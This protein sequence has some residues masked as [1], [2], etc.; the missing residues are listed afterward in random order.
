MTAEARAYQALAAARSGIVTADG[1][2]SLGMRES[3]LRLAEIKIVA[4]AIEAAIAEERDACA[5]IA[6]EASETLSGGNWGGPKSCEYG[7]AEVIADAIQA[8]GK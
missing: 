8:R 5:K 1:Y 3:F 7:C 2:V 6:A 4:D